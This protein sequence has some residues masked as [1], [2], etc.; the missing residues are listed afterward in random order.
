MQRTYATYTMQRVYATYPSGPYQGHIPG[1]GCVTYGS[2][3]CESVIST[4]HPYLVYRMDFSRQITYNY[5]IA[6]PYELDT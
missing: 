2:T 5:C 3:V 6:Y 4:L 1:S